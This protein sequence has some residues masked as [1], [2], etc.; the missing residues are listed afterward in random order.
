[1]V[2]ANTFRLFISS[3]FSDFTAEREALQKRVFPELERFCSERSAG[4]QAIDLRW[5]I[6]E[7]AQQEHDTLRI[8]LEEVRRCQALSPRPNFAVLLGNRYGW[9]PVP[10]RIPMSH[11]DRLIAA[12]SKS[13]VD[14][15]QAGYEGPDLNAVPPVMC[16]P[17]RQ[18]DGGVNEQ[19]G[20][21]L[22]IALRRAADA[23]GFMGDERLPYFTSATH[24]EVALGALAALD[25]SG[26]ALRP[27]EHVNVYV[28]H[29]E[30]L[31]N[32]SSAC[33]FIDWDGIQQAQIPGA[34]QGLA[35]LEGQLRARL[36][37]RVH[38][39][40]ARWGIDSTDESHLDDFCTRFLT[41]Q[42]A[43]IE[44]ELVNRQKLSDSEVR[45]AQHQSFARERARNFVGREPALKRISDYLS[46]P[47]VN[48][49]LIVQ[50]S[51]GTGK[52]ALMAR[53]YLSA[54]EASPRNT[55]IVARF[56]GGVP[57]TES[58][59]TLLTELPADIALAYGRPAPP[60]TTNIKDA[61]KDF[62]NALQ[63]STPA[64]PLILF[65]DA[66]DQL[67]NADG[68]WLLDW[69]PKE[70]S[71]HTRVVVSTR[72]GQTLLSAE[73]RYP[74]AS[75]ELPA[76]TRSEGGHMLDAW[77]AD[78]REAHYNAGIAPSRGRGLEHQ[79][80]EQVLSI[81]E[82]TGK[83]LWLRLAYE[84]A[85]TWHSWDR[86]KGLTETVGGMVTNLITHRLLNGESHPRA[87]ATR[88]M[89]Y[90]T[91]GRF[92]LSEDELNH[93]LATDPEVK[94]EFEAQNAKTGQ[95]WVPSEKRPR[96]PPI[97]WS[98]L[99]LDLQP[100]LAMSRV[101]GTIV[102]RWFHREFNEEISKRLLG[103]RRRRGAIHGHLADTHRALDR[104]SRVEESGDD[105]LYV[106]T[107]PDSAL[108]QAAIR[109]IMEQPWQLAR[110]DRLHELKALLSDFG[111]CQAKAHRI[112][113]LIRD[114]SEL[115]LTGYEC[116]EW[117]QF[118]RTRAPI[119][120]EPAA[121]TAWPANRTFLQ[122]ALEEEPESVVF[123]SANSWLDR[124]KPDWT[125]SRA[126]RAQPERLSVQLL[127]PAANPARNV[128]LDRQG[129]IVLEHTDGAAY[130]Y[131]FQDGRLL[132]PVGVAARPNDAA[133]I[134]PPHTAGKGTLWSLGQGRWF[135]WQVAKNGGGP[136]GTASIFDSQS[137]NWT[138]LPQI[139]H[140]EVWAAAPLKGGRYA[141]LGLNSN[142]GVLAIGS[143]DHPIELLR[144][145]NGPERPG[146]PAGILELDNHGL[147]IWPAFSNGCGLWLKPKGTCNMETGD[148]QFGG[149]RL[150]KAVPLRDASA[151][152]RK[153]IRIDDTRFVTL[154]DDGE[155]RIW[156]A[157]H[158]EGT[159]QGITLR[160]ST[161]PD[162]PL[163]NRQLRDAVPASMSDALA[164]DRRLRRIYREKDGRIFASDMQTSDHQLLEW[165]EVPTAS[166]Q[167]ARKHPPNADQ[168]ALA[169]AEMELD[170][171]VRAPRNWE[172]W[173]TRVAED[174]AMQLRPRLWVAAGTSRLRAPDAKD[175]SPQLW[176][177]WL[178]HYLREDSYR[179]KPHFT[180]SER[181]TLIEQALDVLSQLTP[182]DKNVAIWRTEVRRLDAKLWRDGLVKS[183]LTALIERLPHDE[184]IMLAWIAFCESESNDWAQAQCA[185]LAR[186]RPDS[187][188]LLLRWAQITENTDLNVARELR[189]RAVN[190]LGLAASARRIPGTERSELWEIYLNGRWSVWACERPGPEVFA[191]DG[192][193]LI[194][195]GAPHDGIRRLTFD[196]E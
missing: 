190:L 55:V 14:T 178:Y 145:S 103:S 134:A 148:G 23:A 66:L 138:A 135:R 176:G 11:W 161:Y 6:T 78:T 108:C 186:S 48:S 63:N 39:I 173:V 142:A 159:E 95:K 51:G 156:L 27:E 171:K 9:E 126:P 166:F 119:L 136:D 109:R 105:R 86:P 117:Q 89:T 149:R 189:L 114:W 96:L 71:E 30:G 192:H 195:A 94:A 49:P 69:L 144:I 168:I 160:S 188:S 20:A 172:D 175:Q 57:G 125:V 98:R 15:I 131:D 185:E 44:R 80:R 162:Q 147:V 43:I 83:P 120:R 93:A 158:L 153:A 4:F 180:D 36:P 8:C 45:N 107:N 179:A 38:D 24:Q 72:E 91:A 59:M 99:Y 17:K 177:R 12:A 62:E 76:M 90:L 97:L 146:M 130:A 165:K 110:A 187:W 2:V 64:R 1:M 118:L 46:Q 70:I 28:R 85:R 157:D 167:I 60:I 112:D 81:F 18:S 154:S 84:E 155:V 58:L 194:L 31:P 102:Y 92:G 68:A 41:D 183:P 25:E 21:L 170:A 141:S 26:N 3:T 151:A 127:P 137:G 13:D 128:Y 16:L 164:A 184:D 47:G 32:D 182:E 181:L 75:L 106:Y 87:F 22:R 33:A 174:G 7:Q 73:R 52:S 123:V 169:P 140:H 121:K 34:S 191:V 132:G 67:N 129:R 143:G 61:H 42:K 50:A 115:Q 56:I 100:Y 124:C 40:Q 111:F 196:R 82:K 139:H 19:G 5:G 133:P 88:A 37:G 101:D 29:I 150:W 116:K 79:Q 77:L 104:A 152:I 163:F 113:D 193:R 65:L 10:A 122:L 35:E 53:A 54:V 74:N